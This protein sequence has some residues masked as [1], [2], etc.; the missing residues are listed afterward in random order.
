MSESAC[1]ALETLVASLRVAMRQA[2]PATAF[3]LTD[4]AAYTT[5]KLWDDLIN[6]HILELSPLYYCGDNIQGRP[7]TPVA[8]AWDQFVY[9][10]ALLIFG[11]IILH[12][13]ERR[14]PQHAPVIF[15]MIGMLFGWALGRAFQQL[16]NEIETDRLA[17]LGCDTE[18]IEDRPWSCH[19]A[20]DYRYM[21]YALLVTLM[22]AAFIAL[23]QP[24]T[25][26]FRHA[27][28]LLALVNKGAATVAMIL[29]NDSQAAFVTR[30]VEGPHAAA[31]KAKLLFFFALALTFGGGGL[32]VLS[33]RTR[34]R[35]QV[36][37]ASS[38]VSSA[39][40]RTSIQLL[41]QLENTL[42]WQAGCAWTDF[43]VALSPTFGDVPTTWTVLASDAF[44]ASGLTLGAIAFIIATT[45]AAAAAGGLESGRQAALQ[46][47]SGREENREERERYFLTCALSF[48]VGWAWVIVARDAFYRV[49][50]SARL[51]VASTGS[52]AWLARAFE[53]ALA[54]VCCPLTLWL[55]LAAKDASQR[56][57]DVMSGARRLWRKVAIASQAVIVIQRAVR[58]KREQAEMRRILQRRSSSA[59]GPLGTAW[60]R[61]LSP[62]LLLDTVHTPTRRTRTSIGGATAGRANDSD[63]GSIALL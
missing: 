52:H 36:Q 37:A 5:S 55:V 29:W 62:F 46:V 13:T 34:H 35:L 26:I 30:G 39:V 16:F 9:A 8:E 14:L 45:T 38:A 11:A 6:S 43:V 15:S 32:A 48:F 50:R 20:H 1:A 17:P 47:A 49:S 2:S 7:C 28:T 12:V 27:S 21:T 42:G 61:L 24:L 18:R 56:L 31:V 63:G 4:T 3:F 25:P 22:S 23:L 53:I 57:L 60:Q 54:L 19:V 58:R 40:T 51:F 33:A 44:Q 41:M 10:A 59:D